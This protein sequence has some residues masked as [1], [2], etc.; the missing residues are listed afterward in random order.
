M[1]DT[2]VQKLKTLGKVRV[3]YKSGAVVEFWTQKF[4]VKYNGGALTSVSYEVPGDEPVKP[5]Y[6]GSLE[7]IESVYQIE[8]KQVVDT[9][10][11]QQ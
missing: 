1:S 9:S 2:P 6:F 3:I 4:D 10:E 11:E 5:M 7:R 8:S